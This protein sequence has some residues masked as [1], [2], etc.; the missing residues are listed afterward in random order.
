VRYCSSIID[1]EAT[2]LH[3]QKYF[4]F[5]A[6]Y[7]NILRS[8]QMNWSAETK[9]QRQE[10]SSVSVSTVHR[11]VTI[12]RTSSLGCVCVPIIPYSSIRRRLKLRNLPN[13]FGITSLHIT[14]EGRFISS[15]LEEQGVRVGVCC[16]FVDVGLTPATC[17]FFLELAFG[18]KFCQGIDICMYM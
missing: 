10:S 16:Q 18:S 2:I 13:V 15:V 1:S 7:L 14:G 17:I 3:L 4:I 9:Q 8:L 12:F 11:A 6:E 5:E